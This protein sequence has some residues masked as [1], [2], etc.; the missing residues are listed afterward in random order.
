M[1]GA[2]KEDRSSSLILPLP[3]NPLG[4][5]R[6][7]LPPRPLLAACAVLSLP[8]RSIL[9]LLAHKSA[10]CPPSVQAIAAVPWTP[11]TPEGVSWRNHVALCVGSLQ[12]L[13]NWKI[14]RSVEQLWAGVS[15]AE[16]FAGA[17]SLDFPSREALKMIVFHQRTIEKERGPPEGRPPR[18]P[19]VETEAAAATAAAAGAVEK[20]EAE[21]KGS[22]SEVLISSEGGDDDD[23]E[24]DEVA[25]VGG[26]ILEAGRGSA[27]AN[28]PESS[29]TTREAAAGSVGVGAN[30][31]AAGGPQQGPPAQRSQW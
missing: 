28:E 25:T 16:V 24:E 1:E 5:A 3:T 20:S 13:D 29:D 7:L 30:A 9:A 21:A 2:C 6:T 8:A 23:E 11:N 18:A 12:E 19:A 4:V 26:D 17:I 15:E 31:Q 14:K 22:I 27:E 10:H